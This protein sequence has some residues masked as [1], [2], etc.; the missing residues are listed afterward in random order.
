[1]F[2][3]GMRGS[4][5]GL[6]GSGRISVLGLMFGFGLILILLLPSLVV[7]DL[8]LSHLGFWLNLILLMLS[9]ARPGSLFSADL[10]VLLSL[11]ISSWILLVISCLRRLIQIFPGLLVGICRKLLVLKSLLLVGWMVGLG[12]RLR[13]SHCLGFLVLLFFWGWLRQQEF[14]P[15]GLQDAYIAMIPKADGGST[16]LG[17]RPLSV[18]PVVYRLWASLR[19]GHLREWVE[20][21]LPTS[22]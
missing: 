7:K 6:G 1:M 19:L 22:V 14:G 21:W 13:H 20:G 10:V 2:L 5:G 17:Q 4:V 3:V 15:Q 16:P 11:L 12:T 18:L 9:S 8:E